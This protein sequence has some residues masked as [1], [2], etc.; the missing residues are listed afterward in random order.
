MSLSI[1]EL[2]ALALKFRD[3]RD[4]KQFHHPKDMAMSLCLEAAEVMELMQWRTGAEL[5]QHLVTKRT[6]LADE[7]A[8]VLFWVLVMSHENQINPAE[9][10]VEKMKKNEA[11]Y[12]VDKARGTARKYTEL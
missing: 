9:A 3:D 7:L 11:K 1:E 10:F 12:P 8:D 2:T 5:D 4:W 6:D